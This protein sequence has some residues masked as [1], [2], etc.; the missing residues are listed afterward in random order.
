MEMMNIQE[1]KTKNNR[2]TMIAKLI[3][4]NVTILKNIEE[5]QKQIEIFRAL[6]YQYRQ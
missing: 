5:E 1:A 4:K 3:E 6:E 2:K